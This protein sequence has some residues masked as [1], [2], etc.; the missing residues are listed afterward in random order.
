MPR[1]IEVVP[2]DPNWPRI[3]EKEAQQIMLALG[4]NCLEVH[5]I[6]STSI[7]GLSAKPVVDILP[8]VKDIRTVDSF[9]KKMEEIGY[10]AKGE[11]GIAFR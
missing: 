7:T 9:E 2:Y 4:S 6:G 5:H 11:F 10:R 8:V 1:H 3:F